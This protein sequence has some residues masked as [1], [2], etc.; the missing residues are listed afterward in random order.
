MQSQIK[1]LRGDSLLV[2][3]QERPTSY[4]SWAIYIQGEFREMRGLKQWVFFVLL[5]SV[6]WSRNRPAGE[7]LVYLLQV[8][9]LLPRRR[10]V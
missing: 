7:V 9:R 5:A 2:D 1:V 4:V 6:S 10:A 8:A 3:Q